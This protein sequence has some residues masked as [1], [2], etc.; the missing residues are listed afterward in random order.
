[1]KLKQ[2]FAENKPLYGL[3]HFDRLQKLDLPEN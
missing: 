2:N 1:M 3:L